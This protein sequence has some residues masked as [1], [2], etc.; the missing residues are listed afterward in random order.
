TNC[1]RIRRT[2]IAY[3]GVT[4]VTK[5][6]SIKP[7][8]WDDADLA[9]A[10][11][12]VTLLF[13]ALWNHADDNGRL[14][15]DPR[16]IWRQAMALRP[17]ASPA[18]VHGWLDELNALGKLVRY[19]IDGK[20]YIAICT[21]DRHQHPNRPR[22]SQFPAPPAGLLNTAKSLRQRT[23]KRQ[24]D[25]PASL[26]FEPETA[27]EKTPNSVEAVSEQCQDKAVVVVEVGGGG[28]SPS[29][30]PPSVEDEVETADFATREPE[31]WKQIGKL[32][33]STI[34][35][36]EQQVSAGKPV[37]VDEAL[38]LDKLLGNTRQGQGVSA[39][40]Y[41]TAQDMATTGRFAAMGISYIL[42]PIIQGK[43]KATKPKRKKPHDAGGTET[44]ERPDRTI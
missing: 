40:E 32:A 23:R 38:E 44:Y 16:K 12:H 1:I 36:Y 10:D 37:T 20:Q 21:W 13:I 25:A 7:E 14:E 42:K 6:R 17:S 31:T 18:T 19:G 30:V 28:S 26:D 27:T 2:D 22:P 43:F 11:P 41:F 8:F 29:V 39:V 5:I 24:F 9:Q 35:R 34:R 33:K 3:N 15:D 4:I